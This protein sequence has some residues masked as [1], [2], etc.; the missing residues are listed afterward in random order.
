MV[1]LIGTRN[2]L[3]R[4]DSLPFDDSERVIDCGRVSKI[5]RHDEEGTFAAT[6]EGLYRSTDDGRTW[7][8]VELPEENVW[9]VF[10]ASDGRIYAGTDPARLFCSAD[11]GDTWTELGSLRQQ[12]TTELWRSAF[13]ETAHVRTV[14]SHPETPD[15][16]FAGIEVGGLYRSED[17]GE[18]W[19][20]CEIRDETGVVQDDI[21]EIVSLGPE[22][23][24]VACGRLSIYDRNHAAA[25][26][27]LYHTADAGVT[28][29]RLDRTVDPS[30]FRGLI[31]HDGMLHACGSTTVPPE[32][33]GTLDA[34]A[35]MFASSDAGETLEEAPYPGGPDEMILAYT[36]S[37]DHVFA[38]TGVG[39]LGRIIRRTGDKTWVTQGYMPDDV[40]SLS[41]S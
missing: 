38:G 35:A 36:S 24:V 9:E 4:V 1:G 15:R 28:W 22:G 37:D 8:P 29:T 21:H 7:N 40:L 13:R 14:T 31:H 17:R 39:D 16:I 2:G 41:V 6:D 26:G 19:S 34:G 11:N 25:E 33:T 30:Y 23:Y 10:V 18:S 12:T 5:S 3:Y 20:K 27:G 32:W